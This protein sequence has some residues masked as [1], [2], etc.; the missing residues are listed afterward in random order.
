MREIKEDM[1]FRSFPITA[2]VSTLMERGGR[3]QPLEDRN[4]ILHDKIDKYYC[5]GLVIINF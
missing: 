1:I 2:I 4:P 3:N 5:S